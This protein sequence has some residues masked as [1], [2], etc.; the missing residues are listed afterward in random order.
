MKTLAIDIETYS[1]VDIK[2]S[3]VYRYTEAPDFQILLFAYSINDGPRLIVDL[4]N[5]E[6]I[7]ADVIAALTDSNVI[8]QAFNALFERTCLSRHLGVS[9]SPHSWD[10]TMVRAARL[11]LPLSLDAVA[12]ALKLQVS[13]DSA[14]NAL[15]RYFSIPCKPTKA[16]AGRTRNLPAHDPERWQR[17]KSYCLRDVEVEQTIRYKIESFPITETEKHLYILDQEINDR[18]ILVDPVFVANAIRIDQESR[19]DLTKEAIELTGLTNPNSAAQL[20]TWLSKEV[21]GTVATLRKGDI[22]ELML[23]ASTKAGA[24]VLAIRQEMAKTSVKKYEAMAATAG[25]FSRIRGLF[26]FYGANRTGRWAGRLVQVQ[27]LPQNHLPDLDLA[28]RVVLGGDRE[29]LQMLFGN[30]PDTLSQLIRTAFVAGPGKKLIAVDFAAIELIVL[31]WLA[32]EQW[33]IDEF[34]GK[35]KI[36][37]QTAAR[38]FRIPVE[39]VTKNSPE[40]QKGKIASLACQYGGGVGALVSMGALR[41]GLSESELPAIIK[42]WRAANTNTVQYWGNIER[43]AIAAVKTRKP[44]LVRNILFIYESGI[45]FI[46][47]PS[48]RRLA[49][50]RPQMDSGLYNDCLTYE[51]MDQQTKKWGRIETWGG[52]LVENIVQAVARDCLGVALLRLDAAGYSIVGHVHDEIIIEAERSSDCLAGILDIMT[53]PIT[54]AEGLP[55]AA[56]GFENPYYKK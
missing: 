20:K 45:L 7:P 36:Y 18:G 38:M 15:I 17:F 14:G 49:Y 54:W 4:M 19:E 5:G 47:L 21:N 24:R 41:M 22:P 13:K 42:Q 28:R 40:R 1:S 8:K 51:G 31:A 50:V 25:R 33:V 30:V 32:G 9:L 56:E 23:K 2:T 6:V 37:E 10:C 46:E 55:L 43:A 16:N 12:R 48:G 26:Q 53:R 11:G 52:K 3:G 27:N 35:R 34:T 44:Q 29:L 39:S